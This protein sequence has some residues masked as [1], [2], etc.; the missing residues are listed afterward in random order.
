MAEAIWFLDKSG[1]TRLRRD[2]IE[3]Q[4]VFQPRPELHLSM[5][6]TMLLCRS[7]YLSIDRTIYLSTYQ[8]QL[9]ICLS[10]YLPDYL[11]IYML[12][13]SIHPPTYLYPC[14]HLSI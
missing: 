13:L 3:L 8:Y 10:T 14:I 5:A 1:R 4:Q 11:C 12:Y 9:S 6:L 7:T 2:S